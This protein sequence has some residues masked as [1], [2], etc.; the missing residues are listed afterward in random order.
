MAGSGVFS[1][2]E[3]CPNCKQRI[4][5][6]CGAMTQPSPSPD[7]PRHQDYAG[8]TCTTGLLH[9]HAE[10]ARDD[11]LSAAADGIDVERLEDA[12]KYAVASVRGS[13]DAAPYRD[14]AA[15]MYAR[16]RSQQQG[17]G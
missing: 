16:L 6:Q 1:K 9:A 13:L 10:A 7:Q 4:V 11:G 12:Y 8:R 2:S 17:E 3:T 14:I 5:H 15:A